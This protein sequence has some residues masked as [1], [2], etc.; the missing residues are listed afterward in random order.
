MGPVSDAIKEDH[1]ELEAYYKRIVAST[2]LNEQTRFQKLFTW[3]LARHSISEELVIYPVLEKEVEG[4]RAMADHD[5]SEHQTVKE[6]L[7][8][9]Q[10]LESQDPEFL[11]TLESLMKDLKEHIREEEEQDLVRLEEAIDADK[12]EQLAASFERTKL[13][14][15]TRSHPSAP[16][17][18][19]YETVVGL[20]AAPLDKLRDA[21]S[22]FPSEKEKSDA[23]L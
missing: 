9:F 3:E 11:P 6:K 20:M 14:T 23:K 17:R 5:R 10:N 12:S 19:P 8:K 7:Y 4:G 13:F 22:T 18:P 16:N 2:D 15:P 21:F 1:R